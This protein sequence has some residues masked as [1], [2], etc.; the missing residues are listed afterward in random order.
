MFGQMQLNGRNAEGFHPFFF[1]KWLLWL[2]PISHPC[3]CTD[4][5]SPAL[6]FYLHGDRLYYKTDEKMER[7]EG[8]VR[9]I[10]MDRVPVRPLPHRRKH[11]DPGT[12]T[13]PEIGVAVVDNRYEGRRGGGGRGVGLSSKILIK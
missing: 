9:Y 2:H 6:Q 12:M 4:C 8:K 11:I 5:P 13:T 7:I 3:C 10:P 1:G